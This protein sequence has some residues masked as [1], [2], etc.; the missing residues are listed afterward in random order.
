MRGDALVWRY[1]VSNWYLGREPP[2][3]DVMAWNVDQTRQPAAMHS[4][5][6]R[7]CYLENRLPTPGAAVLDGTPVDLSLIEAP[8]YVLGAETDHITPWRSGYRTTQLVGGD[9]RYTLTSSGHIAGILRPPGSRGGFRI[10]EGVPAGPDEWLR[11]ATPQDGSWWE[12]WAGW[13]AERAGGMVIPP[14][15]S[16]G[17]PAPGRYVHT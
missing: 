3:F 4:Q 1:V 8:V 6:L 12:H 7:L 11:D 15:L 16:V 13:A 10:R 14:A 9:V 5:F 17:E 2:A